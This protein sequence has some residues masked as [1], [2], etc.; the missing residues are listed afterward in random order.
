[1]AKKDKKR[2]LRDNC[3]HLEAVPPEESCPFLTADGVCTKRAKRTRACEETWGVKG[4]SDRA[5]EESDEY[6]LFS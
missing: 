6:V 4:E 3:K 5:S 2:S 1:M